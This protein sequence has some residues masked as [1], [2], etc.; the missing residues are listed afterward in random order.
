MWNITDKGE[1]IGTLGSESGEIVVDLE[2]SKGARLTLEKE[3]VVAPY[4]ITSGVY[5][6]FFHTTYLSTFEKGME[7]INIMKKEI[8]DFLDTET[9]NEE[10]HDW[11][12]SFVDRH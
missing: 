3:C 2:H 5:G 9:T 7:V 8:S 4:S 12:T 11:I 6:S 1:T 10:E